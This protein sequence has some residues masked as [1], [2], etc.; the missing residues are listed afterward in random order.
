MFLLTNA[1]MRHKNCTS[2]VD[3][4]I[5]RTCNLNGVKDITKDTLSRNAY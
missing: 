5:E 2:V 1:I 4:S 3:A